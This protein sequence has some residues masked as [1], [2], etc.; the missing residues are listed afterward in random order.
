MADRTVGDN[1]FKF[2]DIS[3]G[4]AWL[5]QGKNVNKKSG[6]AWRKIGK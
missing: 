1:C 6:R 3:S 2:Y 4:T 5:L